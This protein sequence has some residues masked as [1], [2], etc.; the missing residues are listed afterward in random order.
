MFH[1]SIFSSRPNRLLLRGGAFCVLLSVFLLLYNFLLP[2]D[3]GTIH[4]ERHWANV[5]FQLLKDAENRILYFG[6]SV[7]RWT[8]GEPIGSPGL[9]ELLEAITSRPVIG[10]ARGGYHQMLFNGHLDLLKRENLRPSH[11]ILPINLRS[12]SPSWENST[13]DNLRQRKFFLDL[14]NHQFLA[15]SALLFRVPLGKSRASDQDAVIINKRSIGTLEEIYAGAAKIEKEVIRRRYLVRY[16][17]PLSSSQTFPYLKENLKTLRNLPVPSLVYITPI[18]LEDMRRYLSPDEVLLVEKNL[19]QLNTTLTQSGVHGLDL[20][21]ALQARHFNHS[22]KNPYEHL[23]ES[24]RQIVATRLA[25][26]L[27]LTRTLAGTPSP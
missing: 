4:P 24:G 27:D 5:D 21:R 2:N 14:F 9:D 26:A 12:F 8:H 23:L 22:D 13:Y 15:Q 11:I 19:D 7:M 18:N 25:E 3:F 16:A 6:D 10:L 20:G 1:S 17:T